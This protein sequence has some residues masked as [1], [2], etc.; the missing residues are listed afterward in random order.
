VGGRD[1]ARAS[2]VDGVTLA[3]EHLSVRTSMGSTGAISRSPICL[4]NASWRVLL[5][6]ETH[7]S[8]RGWQW[9]ASPCPP[10]PPRYGLDAFVAMV[11]R[12][13]TGTGLADAE[14]QG[15]GSG[16]R[17]SERA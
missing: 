6:C 13:D 16:R 15:N 3:R 12:G 1:N 8:D 11:N 7:L 2:E 5:V 17:P 9:R 14:G 4:W 10:R